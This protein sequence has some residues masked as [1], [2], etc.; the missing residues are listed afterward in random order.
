MKAA[1]IER[2]IVLNLMVATVVIIW[3]IQCQARDG[4]TCRDQKGTETRRHTTPYP[5]IVPEGKKGRVG[6]ASERK[7]LRNAQ[8]IVGGVQREN[9]GV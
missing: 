5:E 6:K 1:S 3:K 8:Q 4:R 2:N 9:P 7:P